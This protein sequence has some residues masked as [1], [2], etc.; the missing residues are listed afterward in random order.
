M[1][2]IPFLHNKAFIELE[3]IDST[4]SFVK[5]YLSKNKPKAEMVI[6]S[7]AQPAGRGQY[8]N[9][10]LS[11]P[12]KNLTFS[13]L[14][15][16]NQVRPDN[17]FNLNIKVSLAIH[18]ALARILQPLET[19]HELKIKWPN[20]IYLDNKKIGGILIEN[21]IQGQF[22]ESCIIGV[23]LN[24]LQTDFGHLSH[25]ASSLKNLLGIDYPVKTI[26]A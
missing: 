13:Y 17:Q 15:F 6:M 4:N 10:W 5:Q 20:D 3:E 7:H 19:Q 11:E 2:N 18:R 8:G 14:H 24:I 23:G 22:I 26:L 21:T 9:V 12:H 25:K 1:R 16:P